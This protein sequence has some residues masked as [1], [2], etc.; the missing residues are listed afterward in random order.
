MYVVTAAEPTWQNYASHK[1]GLTAQTALQSNSLSLQDTVL[2]KSVQGSEAVA[3][4]DCCSNNN[5]TLVY[6]TAKHQ[7]YTDQKCPY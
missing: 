3:H 2:A 7:L 6:V 4:V 5:S 1:F